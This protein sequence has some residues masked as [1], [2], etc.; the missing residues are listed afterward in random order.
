MSQYPQ[1]FFSKDEGFTLQWKVGE[2]ELHIEFLDKKPEY[3]KV[4][5]T[6]IEDEMAIGYVESVGFDALWEWLTT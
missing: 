4:W 5:G 6:N 1:P 3:T 2:K